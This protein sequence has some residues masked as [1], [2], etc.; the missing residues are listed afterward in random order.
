M[1][2]TF[3]GSRCPITKQTYPSFRT[4]AL[5]SISI[6][7]ARRMNSDCNDILHVHTAVRVT[8]FISCRMYGIKSSTRFVEFKRKDREIATSLGRIKW[9]GWLFEKV[10]QAIRTA[11]AAHVV[12]R[13]YW[14]ICYRRPWWTP[15]SMG[16][17]SAVE[18][19]TSLKTIL[20][21]LMMGTLEL[22]T[23]TIST[24]VR[25]VHVKKSA[26]GTRSSIRFDTAASNSPSDVSA[27][28]IKW[29]QY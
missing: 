16:T 25:L 9:D 27:T 11:T 23:M 7:R 19:R 13:R 28:G 24:I 21:L 26:V 4:S 8:F 2:A 12:Q 5:K 3:Q 10:A 29:W 14:R 17:V 20:E 6:T 22:S 1:A 15:G 18:S